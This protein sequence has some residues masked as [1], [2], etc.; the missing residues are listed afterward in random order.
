MLALDHTSDA[1]DIER[2]TPNHEPAS[3]QLDGAIESG[4]IEFGFGW[5]AVHGA[6]W[7]LQTLRGLVGVNT[8]GPP[9]RALSVTHGVLQTFIRDAPDKSPIAT[10]IKPE[11]TSSKWSRDEEER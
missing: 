10:K 6:Q 7:C 5:A 11:R 2:M 8:R 9:A 4:N 1:A 3:C